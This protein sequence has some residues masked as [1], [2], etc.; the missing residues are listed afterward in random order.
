MQVFDAHPLAV[1]RQTVLTKSGESKV[2]ES[3]VAWTTERDGLRNFSTTLGHNTATVADPS[4]VELVT[5]G[6]LWACRRLD[7]GTLG[8]PFTG[9]NEVT[10]VKGAPP[11]PKSDAAT[12]PDPTPADATL[13]V[14]KASSTQ[15]GNDAW[16]A[17]DGNDGTRWCGDGGGFPQSW[18]IELDRPHSVAG[19][20]IVG[21]RLAP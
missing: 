14:A 17:C 19:I 12:H 2:E 9:K 21:I 7:D 13:V 10:F 6:L 15:P 3:V 1:G 16:K 11:K 8:R 18:Q 4:Y 5:R 20:N